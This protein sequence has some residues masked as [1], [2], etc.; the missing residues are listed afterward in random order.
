MRRPI[1][2]GPGATSAPPAGARR[3]IATQ[4]RWSYLISSTLPLLI[5]GALLLV[6]NLN[7]QQQNVYGEQRASADR[8]ASEISDYVDEMQAELV[9]FALLVRPST[10]QEQLVQAAQEL[11]TRQ[12]QRLLDL[13]VLSDAGA[14]RLRVFR[15][16]VVPAGSLRDYGGDQ[17]VQ[18]ALRFGRTSYTTIAAGDDSRPSFGM[19]LPIRNDAGAIIGALRAQISAEPIR[20]ELRG[21]NT[22]SVRHA[23]LIALPGGN[24]LL[25]DGQPQFT[26]PTEIWRLLR[27]DSGT[28]EY[29]GTRSQSVIG[30]L[31][32]VTA[33]ESALPTGWGVVVERE[34]AEAFASVRR[35]A[36]LLTSLV[37]VVGVLALAW[38]F[39]QT[40]QFLRP[41]NALQAGAVALGDGHLDHRIAIVSRDELGEVAGAFNTMGEHLQ[42][43]LREIEDQN[44]RLR[45]GLALARDIQVGLLPERPPWNGDSLAVYARSIPAY[46]VGGDFYTYLALPEGRAAIA[47]GDISG[48]GVGAALIM[49]LTSSAVESHGR[50]LEH[51]AEVLAALN[52]L[53]APRLKANH[54]NAALLFAVFDPQAQTVRIANA[55][56]IAPVVIAPGGSRLVE[57]GGLPLGTF[58]GAV[59][60]EEV[61]ALGPGEALLLVSDGVVEAHSPAGELFGFERLEAA[62]D[63]VYATGD[64]RALVELVLERVHEHMAD[65]EQHDDITVVAVR[66][67]LAHEHAFADE[68][69]SLDYVAL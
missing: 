56:M 36:L 60:R 53:L 50:E 69:R 35:S 30:A 33:G 38:A 43:S 45:H 8:F 66:P 28:A 68:E 11:Q 59:Y 55:G 25:D 4:L 63:A 57:V 27:A 21:D 7:N 14:E 18:A 61:V 48:K 1:N 26:P 62:V 42:R 40:R 46:D 39:R 9:N 44:E 6:I 29:F 65:A 49:A 64:V 10:P 15:N 58:A 5:V 19:T 51:P 16:Q 34:S 24:V 13:A 52:T 23:Y 3:S 17:A 32:P 22:R 67:P 54:M 2:E 37:A 47:I 41:I 31:T 20:Q 12:F